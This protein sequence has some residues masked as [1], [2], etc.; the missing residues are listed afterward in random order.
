MFQLSAIV[1]VSNFILCSIE[2][3]QMGKKSNYLKLWGSSIRQL[4]H[5]IFIIKMLLIRKSVKMTIVS[6]ALIRFTFPAAIIN[7]TDLCRKPIREHILFL[8]IRLFELIASILN[9]YIL[10]LVFYLHFSFILF[11]LFTVITN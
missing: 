3:L 10:N 4:Y 2:L 5:S 7:L 9:I 1:L 11:F 6:S 8:N